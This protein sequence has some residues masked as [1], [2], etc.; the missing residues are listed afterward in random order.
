MHISVADVDN[1]QS[2]DFKI[3]RERG[4]CDYLFVL[5]KSPS[6]VLTEGEYRSVDSGDYILFDKNSIQSY[7]PVKNSIFLHD[8]MHFDTENRTEEA[9]L[10]T[11]PKDTILFSS[12]SDSVSDMLSEI[13]KE[14]NSPFIKYK[15]ETLSYLGNAFLYRLKNEIE[16]SAAIDIN[17]SHFT[18]LH[19]LRSDLYNNP[20]KMWSVENAASFV[21]FSR[22]HFQRL[23]KSIFSVPFNEDVINARI[24]KAK[25]LL[26]GSSL[27]I[28]EIA[29]KC[30]YENTEHFIRQFKNKTGTTPNKFR[31]R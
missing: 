5:F 26:L 25:V 3:Y 1:V 19:N 16:S 18:R 23:Y 9:L 30:G 7:Y 12:F 2:K 4:R 22:S 6:E 17:K 15:N 20:Q 27:N 31:N 21:Q 14:L 10:S 11:I 13:K 28:N 8:Y 24:S 29:Q